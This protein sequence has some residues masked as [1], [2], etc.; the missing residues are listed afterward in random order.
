VLKFRYVEG[1]TAATLIAWSWMLT[2]ARLNCST[3]VTP[4]T[5]RILRTMRSLRGCWRKI[6][7][8]ALCSGARK[9]PGGSTACPGS[10]VA[11]DDGLAGDGCPTTLDVGAVAVPA[12]EPPPHADRARRGSAQARTTVACAPRLR[13]GSRVVAASAPPGVRWRDRDPSQ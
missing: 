5:W 13:M 4:R 11:E 6:S 1:S 3:W 8:S 10:A 12:D 9:G 2:C 7:M